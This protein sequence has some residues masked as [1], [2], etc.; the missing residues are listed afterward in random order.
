MTGELILTQD[1]PL[2]TLVIT[3]PAKRNAMTAA[4]WAALPGMLEV[5]AKDPVNRVLVVAGAGG[6]FCAGADIAEAAAIARAGDDSL[7]VAAERALAEF[8]RPTIARI[9]GF[10]V[11]GGCQLAVACDL[12]VAAASAR[13][14]VTPA[15]LGIVYPPSTTRRLAALVGPAK[16]KLLL[17]TGELV[18]ASEALRFGLVDRLVADD[19]LS[20]AVDDLA[21]T[22]ATRSRLTLRAAKAVLGDLPV[23]APDEGELAEGVAAFLERRAPNW[24]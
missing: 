17:F 18:D 13:F 22:I 2:A 1:G 11:G 10:C 4:M 15:K 3:N 8:P 7:A 20:A 14:G 24:A 19:L 12:R 9:D 16:A 21:A 5:L 23:P 6:T